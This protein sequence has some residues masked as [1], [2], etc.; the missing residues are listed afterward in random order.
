MAEHKGVYP[1]HLALRGR[2][3][4]RS[5]RTPAA[6][7]A[8]REC[9]RAASSAPFRILQ[10]SVQ[11]DHIHMIAEAQDTQALTNGA[12][13]VSI[14]S[15]PSLPKAPSAKALYARSGRSGTR[16]LRN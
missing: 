2:P 16:P 6:V 7:A 3:G 8:I 12:R 5:F 9:L 13:G 15:R 1:V 14:R 11:A 4:I 10:Y